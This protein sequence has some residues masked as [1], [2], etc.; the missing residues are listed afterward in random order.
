MI[1][2]YLAKEPEEKKYASYYQY[3]AVS[4]IMYVRVYP[5]VYVKSSHGCVLCT[6]F[7]NN[8]FQAARI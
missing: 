3:R 6:V 1:F 2:E 7:G 5:H 8:R 4:R